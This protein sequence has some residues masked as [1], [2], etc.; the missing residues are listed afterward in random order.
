[1]RTLAQT[2]TFALATYR[3]PPD[4]TREQRFYMVAGTSVLLDEVSKDKLFPQM[5]GRL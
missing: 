3:P 1:V 4:W 5:C 2:Q